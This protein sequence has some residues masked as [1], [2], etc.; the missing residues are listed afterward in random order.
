MK[1][2]PDKTGV[3]LVKK[4]VTQVMGCQTVLEEAAFP[5][6]EQ[7]CNMGVFLDPN[8][9]LKVFT[10]VSPGLRAFFYPA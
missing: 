1:L 8:L 3:V 5:L 7:V 9:H 4:S 6:K 10:H 2:N